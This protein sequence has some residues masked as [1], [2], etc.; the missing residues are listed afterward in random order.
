MQ[1]KKS[2]KPLSTDRDVEKAETREELSAIEYK[3]SQLQMYSGPLPPAAE[4]QRYEEAFPGAAQMILDHMSKEQ[5]FRHKMSESDQRLIEK[6]LEL[7]STARTRSQ[8]L[9]FFSI[10]LTIGLC[11]VMVFTDNATEAKWVI[12]G[13]VG[14]V[15]LLVI[16]SSF[17]NLFNQDRSKN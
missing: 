3:R 13:I 14:L 15:A 6:D 4:L 16:K 17:F 2:T 9:I 12:G 5:D 1:A 8:Y 11:A 7:H 10:A